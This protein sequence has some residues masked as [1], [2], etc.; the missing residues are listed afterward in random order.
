MTEPSEDYP[1]GG[2]I[3]PYDIER[4]KNLFELM[5]EERGKKCEWHT[6]HF[7]LD[8][9]EP[10]IEDAE[11]RFGDDGRWHLTGKLTEEGKRFFE[12]NYGQRE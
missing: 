12:G 7:K 9:G 10:L 5:H 1:L 4:D 11:V 2:S 3:E 8:S 6:H